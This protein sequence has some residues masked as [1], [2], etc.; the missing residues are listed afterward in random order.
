MEAYYLEQKNKY[1]Y[2]LTNNI[3]LTNTNSTTIDTSFQGFSNSVDRIYGLAA[4]IGG[5]FARLNVYGIIGLAVG[6][7]SISSVNSKYASLNESFITTSI[8]VT[9]GA[10]AD[11]FITDNFF[12]SVRYQ[13]YKFDYNITTTKLL[14]NQTSGA[15]NLSNDITLKHLSI[16]GGIKFF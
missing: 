10:G 14:A 5:G 3:Y 4:H 13:E 11:F 1:Q 15:L 9:Y 2:T 7:I 16:G 6:D 12:L 8:G